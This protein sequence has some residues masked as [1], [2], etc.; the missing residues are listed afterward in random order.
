MKNNTNISQVELVERL[1]APVESF[2]MLW[3]FKSALFITLLLA[4]LHSSQ[5]LNHG[6]ALLELAATNKKVS[7]PVHNIVTEVK[8]IKDTRVLEKIKAIVEQQLRRAQAAIALAANFQFTKTPANNYTFYGVTK[9]FRRVDLTKIALLSQKEFQSLLLKDMP[10]L[11][12]K[13]SKKYLHLIVSEAQKYQVDPFWAIAVAWVESAFNVKARSHLNATGLMQIMPSTGQYLIGILGQPISYKK[14]SIKIEEPGV[15]VKLG[16]FYLDRLLKT[17]KGNYI[18]ATCSY[19]MG[20]TMVR[21]RLRTGLPVG[22]RNQYLDRVTAAYKLLTGPYIKHIKKLNHPYQFSF[23]AQRRIV[24]KKNEV[25]YSLF[26]FGLPKSV[27]SWS[28][29]KWSTF[30]GTDSIIF[31]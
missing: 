1:L 15:N 11:I 3:L 4:L 22:K 13:R 29:K 26:P 28:S 6:P 21:R 10:F 2:R 14:A 19:N 23:A 20:P 31:L 7:A 25:R 9:S 24:N 17:F 16:V 5:S 27:A 18:L 30:S 12:K 8:S